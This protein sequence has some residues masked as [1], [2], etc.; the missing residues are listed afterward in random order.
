M[1]F[2]TFAL[3]LYTAAWSVATVAAEEVVPVELPDALELLPV[4][5][6]LA[7]PPLADGA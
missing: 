1:A 3:A 6:A 4:E 2:L 7:E 5:P